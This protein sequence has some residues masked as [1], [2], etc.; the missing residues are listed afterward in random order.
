[1]NAEQTPSRPFALVLI[2]A[3]YLFSL[4]LAV[5][6]YGYPFPFLGRIYLGGAGEWLVLADSIICLYLVIGIWKRQKLTLWFLI[7][8]NLFDIC[9]AYIN[10]AFLPVSAYA[11]LAGGAIS[12]ADLQLNTMVASVLLMLLNCYLL[13][14]R[15]H[16]NN[17][18]PYLF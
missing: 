18:S 1:V 15:R 14:N 6:N 11:Q 3:I 5:S 12:E 13:R 9:N 8:Y 2:A 17:K 7:G 4:L 16:F 10:L